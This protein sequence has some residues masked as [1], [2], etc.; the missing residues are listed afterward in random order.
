[1]CGIF[2]FFPL[3][4]AQDLKMRKNLVEQVSTGFQRIWKLEKGTKLASCIG[5]SVGFSITFSIK[6]RKK[7]TRSYQRFRIFLFSSIFFRK[8]AKNLLFRDSRNLL[9]CPTPE[10]EKISRKCER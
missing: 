6:T 8:R 9:L 10:R 5:S 1:M 4:A 7:M 3:Q 2:C